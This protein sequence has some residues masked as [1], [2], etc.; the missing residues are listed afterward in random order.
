MPLQ[1]FLTGVVLF[2]VMLGAVGAATTLV[3]RRRLMHLD[4]LELALASIV[5]GT[6]ILICVHLVPLMLA[7]LTRGTVIASSLVAV[8]LAALVRPVAAGGAS[9]PAPQEPPPSSPLS[10]ALAAV[11]SAFAAVASL[12]DLGHWAGDELVGVDPLTFHLPN[13]GRWIQHHT[14]WQIDQFV[15]LL[16]HGN[17][18]NN[19]DVVLLSTVLPWRNDFLVRLP[20]T[21]FL[22]TT[23]IAVYAVGRELRA[24]RAASVLA[25]AA[26]VSLPVVGI[27]TIPRAL[28]DSLMWTTFACGLLFLLRHVRSGRRSDL[29]L[30]A[31]GMGIAAG[32]KWYGVSSVAVVV[33]VWVV[34]RLVAARRRGDGAVAISDAAILAGLSLLGTLP[35]LIRNLLLSA[36]PLFPLK[37]APFGLTIFDA[38]P[39]VIREQAGFTIADYFGN[40]HVLWQLAGEMIEGLGWIPIVCALAIAAAV[41]LAR[42]GARAA[43]ERI[44]VL[45]IGAI[46]L[47]ALYVVTPAT[48]LGLKNDPSLA[49]AN[50]RYA[51]PALI[52][53][54]PIVAW[55]A[56][57]L[58]RVAAV[59][60]EGALGVAALLGAYHGYEVHGLREI[61]LATVGLAALGAAAYALWRLRTRRIVLVAAGLLA[62]VVGLAATHR[63]ED[64]INSGRYRGVDPA[65]D[66]LLA[67]AP[68]GHRIGLASNWSVAGLSPIWP[69]FGT[70]IGNDVEFVGHFVRGFMTPYD[71]ETSFQA[72]LRRGRFDLL[73]VG[74]GFYPPQATP[75]QRW[76]IDAGWKTIALSTRLRVLRAPGGAAVAA[77]A[78]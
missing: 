78:G 6:S 54:V 70:R 10:W 13:V 47:A 38:P 73:V 22:V 11:A 9:D 39:D 48:A 43:D 34:A 3:V 69:A 41:M 31:I 26:S 27:A 29:V 2:V 57:R 68:S 50:T 52:I 19:G 4:R 46:V 37:V 75:E 58:P 44:I 40:A 42:R 7:I 15:P 56:G 65:I 23:A 61:G 60:L 1:D 25:A 77:S 18:P 45:A 67:A 49:H 74:R 64:R 30:G 32:T 24:P 66:A 62:V 12:A 33:L 16:A 59:V 8:G 63:I 36:N 55:A 21:F 71:T 76:A 28:P 5:V 72:A 20:I 51:V 35:W 17:Y 14:M 53:A